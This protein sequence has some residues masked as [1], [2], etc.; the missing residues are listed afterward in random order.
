VIPA[1]APAPGPAPGPHWHTGG[2][3]EIDD[4]VR[5]AHLSHFCPGGV[6]VPVT[7]SGP[8]GLDPG[9][10]DPALAVSGTSARAA[11]HPCGRCGRPIAAG[12]DARRRASG[13]WVHENCPA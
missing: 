4:R 5:E 12:Q 13:A 3:A 9:P 7:G 8:I 1:P 6:G 2:V 11:G 10:A